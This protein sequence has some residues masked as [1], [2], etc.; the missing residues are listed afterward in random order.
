M[1]LVEREL[2]AAPRQRRHRLPPVL[3]PAAV[4][5]RQHDDGLRPRHRR[6]VGVQRGLP[7]KRA[8]SVM[9]D[10]GFWHNGLTSGIANAVFNRSD[11]LTIVVD[12]N[13]TSATGGQDL[14]SSRAAHAD[15]QHRPRDR[16]GGARR[17]RRVGEDDDAA[18]TTSS[19]MRDALREALTTKDAG[20]EGAGRAV[21]VHAQPAAAREAARQGGD[22]APA[23][24]SCASASASTATPAPATTRA[25]ASPAARR[26]RSSPTPTR[27]A[28]TRSRPCSTAASAAASAARSRTRPCCARRST[29]R[30]SSATRPAGTASL[31]ARA[32]AR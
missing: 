2:G 8:I 16:A 5:P 27:C 28:P 13:Y 24:A 6:R 31:A 15:A 23:S 14:L 7:G 25:S 4:P 19:A 32:R 1:K 18:P 9:G 11:N 12:N 20:P 21:G 17:R 26:S 3:D 22:R 10:G 29:R 30:G